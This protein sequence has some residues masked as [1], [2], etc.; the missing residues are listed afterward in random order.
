MD[1]LITRWI[2]AFAGRHPFSDNVMIWITTFGVPVMVG[3]VALQWFA[4][5]E[6][7]HLRFVAICAGL[8]FLLGLAIN[9]GLL[10]AIHR[11]RPYD[12]GVSH[13]LIPPSLD[14]SFPS[15]HA[16]AVAAIAMAFALAR[17][18]SRAWA[19]FGMAALVSLSRIYVGTHYATDV[20]GG[21]ATG[22]LAAILVPLIYRE[23]SRL[24]QFA[25]KLM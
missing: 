21:A 25:I 20:V 11:A 6:R 18:P 12:V 4:K 7:P 16:T 24:N 2:N 8:S 1:I 3:L 17:L 22:I 14:W 19:F 5:K 23:D 15:D 13:L 10:F 9:Q